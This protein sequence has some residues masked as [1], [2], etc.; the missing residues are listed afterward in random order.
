MTQLTNDREEIPV[1]AW[2]TTMTAL[3]AAF[4]AWGQY[5]Y[6][7][8]I[9]LSIYQIFPLLGLFA[10]SILWSQYMMLALQKFWQTEPQTLA[11]YFKVTGFLVLAV[12]FIH[13]S[14]LIWQLWRDGFGLPPESYIRHFV[15]PGLGWVTILG[16]MSF[17]IFAAYE[18]WRLFGHAIWMRFIVYAA[19]L[20]MFMVFYHGLRLGDQLQ[21]G[22]FPVLWICYGACLLVAIPYLRW[23]SL[24][25]R[26]K[27]TEKDT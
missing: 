4:A 10:F 14:L 1:I 13:P 25:S 7:S 22:W 9:G 23:D 3:V 5:H 17:G 16:T 6:W 21:S 24:M 26:A 15:A 2:L 12:I 8:L 18:L 27:P 19:D 11:P 20:A